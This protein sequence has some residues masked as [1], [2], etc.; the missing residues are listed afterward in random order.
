M[1]INE[2]QDGYV[3]DHLH[4]GRALRVYR[5]LNLDQLDCSVAIIKNAKSERM[6]RKDIIKIDELIPLNMEII[7]YIDP[8]ATVNVIQDGKLVD[9]I[10]LTVPEHVKGVLKCKNPRC[11]TQTE[12]ELQHMFVLKDRQKGTYR[13]YYCDTIHKPE[14]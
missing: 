14:D 8:G 1:N 11:I 5:Y 12:Q 13:C 3:I 9:K 7:S 4:A 2:I 6:G 10:R